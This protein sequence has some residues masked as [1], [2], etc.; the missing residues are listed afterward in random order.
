MSA[1]MPQPNLL[2]IQRET[3]IMVKVT[4]PANQKDGKKHEKCGTFTLKQCCATFSAPVAVEKSP[5]KA[6]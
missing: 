3:I 5:M 2:K 1:A 4:A 6:E